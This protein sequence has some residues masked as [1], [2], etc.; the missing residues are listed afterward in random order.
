MLSIVWYGAVIPQILSHKYV[1]LRVYA[2]RKLR[3]VTR[4]N[5]KEYIF[6][7]YKQLDSELTR[8]WFASHLVSPRQTSYFGVT[9]ARTL[10][11][12]QP[13]ESSQIVKSNDQLFCQKGIFMAHVYELSYN[14]NR[15]FTQPPQSM[16]DILSCS[17]SRSNDIPKVIVV[18]DLLDGCTRLI[19]V[20]F[21][22]GPL[23]M[24]ISSQMSAAKYSIRLPDMRPN[25]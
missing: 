17:L 20:T 11:M 16:R 22:I 12:D 4:F 24:S 18:Y 10:R 14:P 23:E 2:P 5:G 3:L 19:F 13:P 7:I 6:I 1:H 21:T 9:H 15:H 8:Q 25:K